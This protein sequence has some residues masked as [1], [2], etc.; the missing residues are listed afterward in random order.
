MII[1]KDRASGPDYG[2]DGQKPVY[3]KP[4]AVG[5]FDVRECASLATRAQVKLTEVLSF[6][7]G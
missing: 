2:V 7:S 5:V 3:Q 1:V 6:V 4:F